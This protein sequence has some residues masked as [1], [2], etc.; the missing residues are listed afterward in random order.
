[1]LVSFSE[2]RDILQEKYP[3]LEMRELS[4]NDFVF[5]QRVRQKCYYCKNYGVKYTCPPRLPNVDFP[6]MFAEYAHF[7]VVICE[8]LL[9]DADFEDQ[10]RKSTNMV[11]RAL[12]F[13][14]GELY[15]RNESM[16][17]SYIG[18]SCKLCKDGCNPEHC[19]NPYYSRIP[20]EGTGCNVVKTLSNVG[21]DV[22]FPPKESL[23]RYGL[24]MW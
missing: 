5:E 12:L 16:A 3:D 1:M 19:A 13:L 14:E 8:I 2:L 11:H 18:G 7:A 21:I 17:L 22:V 9:N 6:T 20:W 24:I 10:R 23:H 15:K 4:V